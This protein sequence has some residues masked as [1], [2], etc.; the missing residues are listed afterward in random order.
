M[1]FASGVLFTALVITPLFA[2]PK[3]AALFRAWPA[4]AATQAQLNTCASEETA[5]VEQQLGDVYKRLLAKAGSRPE[6]VTSIKTAQKAW[7]AY[8]DA[9]MN[10]AYPPKDKQS[11]YGSIYPMEFNLLFAKLTQQQITALKDLLDRYST[12]NQP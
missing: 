3:Q 9:Y 12:A 8:R 4:K 1:R 11:E 7:V 5:R 6:A 10:A 2:A